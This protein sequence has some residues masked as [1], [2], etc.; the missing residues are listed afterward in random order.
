LGIVAKQA[1]KN[2]VSIA[3][4]TIAGA[5]NTILVLPLAFGEFPEGWGLVSV[6]IAWGIILS[7]II[8]GGISNLI[9]RFFNNIETSKKAQFLGFAMAFPL[10][11]IALLGLLLFFGGTDLFALISR[12]DAALLE[13][14]TLK[15]LVLAS[16]L[17]FFYGLNGYVSVILK[18]SYFQFLQEVWLK[19][20][21]LL[22]TLAYYFE[23]LTFEHYLWAY[24]GTYCVATLLLFLYAKKQAL[25]LA[26]PRKGLAYGEYVVY[27]LYS[28]LDKGANIFVNKL[29]I[30]MIAF[31]IG[32]EEVAFYTLAFYIG[33]VTMIPQKSI[34]SIANPL[35][36]KAL[37]EKNRENLQFIYSSSSMIQLLLGGLI[38]TCTW[39]SVDE[40]MLL[41]PEK[42]QGSEWVIFY[43]GLSKLFNM[44][45][46][47]SGGLLV[48]SEHFKKNFYLNFVLIILTIITN[49]LLISPQLG[50]L[51]ITGAAMATAIALFIYN[52]A[53]IIIAEREFKVSPFSKKFL[54]T[55]ILIVLCSLIE[56]WD[57]FEAH[58]LLLIVVKSG[59]CFAMFTALA[60]IF[61]LAPELIDFLKNPKSMLQRD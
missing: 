58:P 43:I 11:G 54:L 12:E 9:I 10:I 38:F 26:W 42:F 24:V 15:L 23:L 48:Y 25:Q 28:V 17:A 19:V 32:L 16:S 4:G 14:Q 47:V 61:R 57:P 30:I 3:I 39:V 60:L 18:T 31:M 53:K 1:A 6:L 13:G 51:G 49:Y 37:S 44:A 50:N 36:A 35:A 45:A 21:Y 7:Q 40:I 41:L 20:S 27:S 2:A 46:G 56:L 59:L 5:V 52:I 22:L 8:N 29:D 34:I 33:S 55:S